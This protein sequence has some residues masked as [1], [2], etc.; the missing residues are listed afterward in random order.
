MFSG[1]PVLGDVESG[2]S[3]LGKK[4]KRTRTTDSTSTSGSAL[5]EG[6]ATWGL[7]QY[8]GMMNPTAYTGSRPG[9]GGPTTGQV[10]EWNML[11]GMKPGAITGAVGNMTPQQIADMNRKGG[12][13][14]GYF[15]PY[16]KQMKQYME[17]DYGEALAMMENQIG[18]GAR[19]ANAFGGS[20]HGVASGVGG[21]KAMDNYLR[22]ATGM[23]AQAYENAMQWQREDARD[24]ASDITAMNQVNLGFGDL[25]RKTAEAQGIA[26]FGRAD[27]FSRYGLNQQGQRDKLSAFD[28]GEFNRQQNWKPGMLDQYMTGVASAPWK[29]TTTGSTTQTGLAKS[30]FEKALGL[31]MGFGSMAMAGG[32]KPFSS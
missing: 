16:R 29:T 32:W 30:P 20:R 1:I 2:L 19:G 8:K 4:P 12:P 5:G 22:A 9:E 7:D 3:G 24:R 17:D 23:D 18:S 21:A 15:N 14:E 25:R 27:R 28:Y 26:D 6:Y 31:G 11:S 13:D 10:Q